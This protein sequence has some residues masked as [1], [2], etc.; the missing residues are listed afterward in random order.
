MIHSPNLKNIISQIDDTPVEELRM[1]LDEYYPQD[2]A[3]EYKKLDTAEQR[4][5]FDVLS[6][7]QGALVFAE[8]EPREIK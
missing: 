3:E 7:E 2:I 5:L 6:Y 8:L 1:V 4:L